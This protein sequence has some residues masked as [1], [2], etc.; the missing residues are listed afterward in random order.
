MGAVNLL[1]RGVIGTE[2][3][4]D[5]STGQWNASTFDQNCNY[6]EETSRSRLNS[7]DED[8]N[9]A[10]ASENDV[11]A[12]SPPI[13]IFIISSSEDESRES[14]GDRQKQHELDEDNNNEEDDLGN[15]AMTN[16][17]KESTTLP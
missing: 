12:K 7:Q 9:D 17:K 13:P 16:H 10:P 1:T 4:A 2:K 15:M 5:S 8:E 14:N 6:L 11:I 3:T